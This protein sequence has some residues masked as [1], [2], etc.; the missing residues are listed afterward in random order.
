[1]TQNSWQAIA[2]CG[3]LSQTSR[4]STM[5][6]RSGSFLQIMAKSSEYL[7]AEDIEDWLS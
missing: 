1:M 2:Y 7:N 4:D 3:I 6:V 5:P